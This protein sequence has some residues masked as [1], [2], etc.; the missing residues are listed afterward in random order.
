MRL[1]LLL[2]IYYLRIYN[3]LFM[4][5]LIIWQFSLKDLQINPIINKL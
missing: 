3:L 1:T 4:Y 2:S 5:N